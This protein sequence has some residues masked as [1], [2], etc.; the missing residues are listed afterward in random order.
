M[1]LVEVMTQIVLPAIAA[2]GAGIGG[3]LVYARRQRPERH[4]SAPPQPSIP[5]R[6]P[7]SEQLGA[8]WARESWTAERAARE[9][10]EAQ[11][12]AADVEA[13]RDAK[14]RITALERANS[15]HQVELRLIGQE[16][17]GLRKATETNA[18]LLGTLRDHILTHCPHCD[19]SDSQAVVVRGGAAGRVGR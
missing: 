5:P 4:H 19:D 15:N 2:G 3:G 13:R 9:I 7:R 11:A 10:A 17:S 16:M 8:D 1:T 14:E 12:K 6:V 18:A